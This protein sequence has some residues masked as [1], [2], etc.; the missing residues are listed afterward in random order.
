MDDPADWA[1]GVV[2]N[3]GDDLVFQG[4]RQAATTF[5][6]FAPFTTFRSILFIDGGFTLSGNQLT[7][8]SGIFTA[9][10]SGNSE[11]NQL[12]RSGAGDDE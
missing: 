7:V 9:T 2:P 12:V 1:S 3:P 5:N 10:N 6:D 8:I 11:I 4:S